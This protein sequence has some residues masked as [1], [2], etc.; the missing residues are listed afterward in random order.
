M[1]AKLQKLSVALTTGNISD[2][3]AI[4]REIEAHAAG[5]VSPPTAS[6]GVLMQT[7]RKHLMKHFGAEIMRVGSNV[8][9]KELEDYDVTA[10][11]AT[12]IDKINQIERENLRTKSSR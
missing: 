2:A 4:Y 3:G 5:I 7:V 11:L 6:K 12:V 9:A 1:K 8:T 10:E